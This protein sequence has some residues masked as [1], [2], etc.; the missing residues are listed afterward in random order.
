MERIHEAYRDFIGSQKRKISTQKLRDKMVKLFANQLREFGPIPALSTIRREQTKVA[1]ALENVDI[2][3]RM[4]EIFDNPVAAETATQKPHATVQA[5]V[6]R[7]GKGRAG[8]VPT[9][10]V[11]S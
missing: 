11:H 10:D 3:N 2:L 4:S 7:R 6:K 1:S 9:G 5:T 8:T